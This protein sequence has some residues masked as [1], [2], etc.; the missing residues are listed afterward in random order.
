MRIYG[1]TTQRVQRASGM[2][3]SGTRS[4]KECRGESGGRKSSRVHCMTQVFLQVWIPRIGPI[5]HEDRIWYTGLSL[6]LKVKGATR[7][8]QV[9]FDFFGALDGA[10][11]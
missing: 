9:M 6:I 2:Q 5:Q 1:Y 11:L 4:G 3:L 8:A 7:T 10:L